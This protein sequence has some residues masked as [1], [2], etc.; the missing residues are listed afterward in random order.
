MGEGG[1]AGEASNHFG[2]NHAG[3]GHTHLHGKL[4]L[5]LI[6]CLGSAS[7][8]QM[9]RSAAH[10]FSKVHLDSLVV[11]RLFERRFCPLK[12]HLLNGGK[13]SETLVQAFFPFY[14]DSRA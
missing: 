13:V 11:G 14:D 9:K 5:A 7:D 3:H 10:H 12:G 4:T 1:A 6:H 8:C 2:W